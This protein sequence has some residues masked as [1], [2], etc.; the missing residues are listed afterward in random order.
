MDYRDA[1]LALS[2]VASDELSI[3]T[4]EGLSARTLSNLYR[5]RIRTIGQLCVLR[6]AGLQRLHFGRKSIKELRERLRRI[7][8]TI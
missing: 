8:R 3:A 1:G 7:G 5:V 6:T 2:G 4:L